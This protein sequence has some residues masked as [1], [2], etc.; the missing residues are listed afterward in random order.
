[1]TDVLNLVRGALMGTANIIPGVSGGTMALVLGI[2]ERL[3]HAIREAAGGLADLARGRWGEARRRLLGLEWR[4][5]LLLGAGILAATVALAAVIEGL[6]QDH[7][8]EM[9][10]LFFGLVAGSIVIA[11]RLIE[12]PDPPRVA[13]MVGVAVA[14]FFLLGL[15]SSDI[16]HPAVWMY[17]LAGAVAI[18]AMILPGVSG[19]FLLLMIGMYEA[20]LAIVNDRDLLMIAV[21]GTGA[22]L[23]LASFSTLLDRL[24]RDHHD[25]VM[26]ALVGLMAGS[27]RVLWPWPDG[28]DTAHLA[29]PPAG[30]WLGPLLFAVAGLAVVAVIAVVAE[31]FGTH[32]G[33]SD[34]TTP[35]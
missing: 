35:E 24:L 3:I 5:V 1:M 15:S 6:L 8:A 11:W 23:G 22:A 19:S 17:F 4:F 31:R 32:E 12:T 29:A 25:T 34:G 27:L 2:Y 16:A 21:F 13:V 33:G 7:P 26:A 30:E 10:A 9:A 20:T 14:A 28:V 18:I